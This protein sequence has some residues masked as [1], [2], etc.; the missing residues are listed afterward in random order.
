MITIAAGLCSGI[1][2]LKNFTAA[3]GASA[4]KPKV[5]AGFKGVFVA[6]SHII[7]VYLK[8]YEAEYGITMQLRF[9]GELTFAELRQAIFEALHEIE[10]DFGIR[11]SRGLVMYINPTDGNG[12]P[13]VPRNAGGSAVTKVTKR[14][15]YNCAA[16]HY[17]P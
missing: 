7:A 5:S 4:A 10:E 8:Y 17:T 13:V 14:G 2:A 12:A 11:H 16:D 6:G 3:H 15:P 9:T 1:S